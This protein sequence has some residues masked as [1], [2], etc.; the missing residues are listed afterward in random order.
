MNLEQ[1]ASLVR[2]MRDRQRA[3]FRSRFDRDL[4][5]AKEAE[6]RVDAALDRIARGPDLF[7]QQGDTGT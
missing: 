6:A 5:D 2:W 1:F 4:R 3:Y 7:E